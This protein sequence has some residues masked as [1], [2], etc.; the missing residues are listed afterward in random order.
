MTYQIFQKKVIE[1]IRQRIPEDQTVFIQAVA[2]NNG[3]KLDGLVIMHRGM[4]IAPTIYLNY[5]YHS[6]IEEGDLETVCRQIMEDYRSGCP[7]EPVDAEFFTDFENVRSQVVYK[8]INFEK[9]LELLDEVPYVRFLDLAVV[10]CCLL[11][12]SDKMQ[13]ASILIRSSHMELWGTSLDELVE[14][15]RRNT[16]KLLGYELQNLADVLCESGIPTDSAEYPM[17]VLT[18]RSHLHGACCILYA[19]LLKS[20]A[21]RMQTDLF[22]LPSSIH[23]VI[24]LPAC[25]KEPMD[26]L[27]E[28]V[29]E[30]N[31][32]EIAAEDV[33]AD[34][35]YYY[36]R[37]QNRISM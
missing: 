30:I 34:H 4:N 26:S 37:I 19:D 28:M 25:T 16:P 21:E 33:L 9:N 5:Y 7:T 11:P 23:E 24:L 8:L 10:F 29:R 1:Y 31:E 3:V 35:A 2:K 27:S 13:S 36:S 15:S 20:F 12:A 6:Y 18:S 22:I 14:L 32:T 17:F